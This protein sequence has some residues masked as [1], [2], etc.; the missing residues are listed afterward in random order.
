MV[1]QKVFGEVQKALKVGEVFETLPKSSCKITISWA[2]SITGV[3]NVLYRFTAPH[4]LCILNTNPQKNPVCRKI[5]FWQNSVA[6]LER[7]MNRYSYFFCI[8]TFN[9]AI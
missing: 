2:Q 6:V 3:A 9:S 1:L 8:Y 5:K 4:K 7:Y